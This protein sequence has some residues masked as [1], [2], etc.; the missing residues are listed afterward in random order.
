MRTKADLKT[1]LSLVN[2]YLQAHFTN[3]LGFPI[4]IEIEPKQYFKNRL[5]A[6]DFYEN[7][8][9]IVRNSNSIS[10]F[11]SFNLGY[12]ILDQLNLSLKLV[13]GKEYRN[14]RDIN[15]KAL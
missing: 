14:V 11:D 8:T 12:F 13:E 4:E 2:R 9:I 6:E 7:E 15:V 10:F 1:E 5:S 3:Y